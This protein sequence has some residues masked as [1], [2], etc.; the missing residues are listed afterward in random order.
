MG[1]ETVFPRGAPV[2]DGQVDRIDGVH[3]RPS[4]MVQDVGKAGDL[5]NGLFKA[6]TWQ[7]NLVRECRTRLAIRPKKAHAALFYSQGPFGSVE[8]ESLHAGCPVLNG[9][10]W[11]ANLWVWN[12]IRMGY[13]EAPRKPGARPFDSGAKSGRDRL[14]GTEGGGKQ[15]DN[16]TQRRARFTNKEVPGTL[17]LWW[18]ETRLADFG[19]RADLSFNTF[20]GHRWSVRRDGGAKESGAKESG[21]AE[22]EV[23]VRWEIGEDLEVQHFNLDAALV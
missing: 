16:E 10:K 19:A 6:G 17:G 1:G 3:P 4:E 9:T 2:E 8:R 12:K 7:A 14:L 5:T 23:V 15:I 11:A 18:E 20:K 22:G 13:A 21:V